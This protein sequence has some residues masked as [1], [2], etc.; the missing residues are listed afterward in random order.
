MKCL[1]MHCHSHTLSNRYTDIH[2]A[3]TQ[4]EDSKATI[5]LNTMSLIFKHVNLLDKE[6]SAA[7]WQMQLHIRTRDRSECRC[8]W[9]MWPAACLKATVL[10][11]QHLWYHLQLDIRRTQTIPCWL[12]TDL[13]TV[14]TLTTVT[15]VYSCYCC[16]WAHGIE[17]ASLHCCSHTSSDRYILQRIL[18]YSSKRWGTRMGK[19]LTKPKCDPRTY[20]L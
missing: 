7:I 13:A 16:Q 2:K 11:I 18:Q 4:L 8:S 6:R 5:Y 3:V 17:I 14:H 12:S 19:L 15:R 20:T 9:M 1:D 10:L